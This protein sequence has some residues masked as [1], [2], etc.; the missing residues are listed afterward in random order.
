MGDGST[1][2]S[3]WFV[4]PLV[5]GLACMPGATLTGDQTEPSASAS[6]EFAATIAALDDA[7]SR[8]RALAELAEVA[9]TLAES[10][11]DPRRPGFVAEVLPALARVYSRVDDTQRDAI[12]AIATQLG[13]PE[14]GSVWVQALS[15]GSAGGVDGSAA[16]LDRAVA[17]LAA[18]RATHAELVAADLIDRFEALLVDPSLDQVEGR[19]GL[20]RVELAKTLGAVAGRRG[21]QPL[22]YA[23][24]QPEV[25]IAVARAA[26]DALGQIGD[27]AAV[28]GLLTA[29]FSIPDAPGTQSLTERAVRAVAAIGEPAVPRVLAALE[30]K[31]LRLS[32]LVQEL[33]FM[34]D[35]VVQQVALSWLGAIGSA[36]AVESI[37]A[38]MPTADCQPGASVDEDEDEQE[39]A[40]TIIGVRAAAA[41]ALGEIGDPRAVDALCSCRDATHEPADLW[42]IATAL[43]RIGGDAAVACLDG[44]VRDGFYS[45]EAVERKFEHEIRWEG[46]RLLILAGSASDVARIRATIGASS[47]AV[48]A[49][50]EAHGYARGLSVLER[51]ASD[52]DCYAEVLADPARSG[53]EREVAGF[54]L[55]RAARPGDVEVAAAL[56]RAFA[57]PD[58][59]ARV[60]MAWWTG[61]VAAGERCDACVEALTEV[62]AAEQGSAPATMLLAWLTARR[63]LAKLTRAHAPA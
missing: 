48:Q 41:R 59:D 21:V 26:V 51:C 46:V 8:D 39:A 38:E 32:R 7:N 25:D 27:P 11:E 23:L 44:I 62:M 58:P 57:V 10:P 28:D 34:D 45:R 52:S 2:G 9:V 31:D 35:R 6:G 30:G 43:G 17:A 36:S 50:I 24:E 63:T 37:V 53:F 61:R 42:E 55:A 16:G 54:Q 4:S 5:L 29:V 47:A 12:L 19:E 18:I 14:G 22:L 15:F 13:A 40:W 60:H 20:L 49:E 56:A 3:W 1:R 33:G